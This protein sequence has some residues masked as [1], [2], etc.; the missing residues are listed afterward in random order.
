MFMK[1]FTHQTQFTL[2]HKWQGTKIFIIFLK[3]KERPPKRKIAQSGPCEPEQLTSQ[4][5]ER[6]EPNTEFMDPWIV[7]TKDGRVSSPLIAY[8]KWEVTFT[9]WKF[10]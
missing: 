4:P 7:N 8:L 3:S 6:D 9:F 5:N 1:K 10:C 2:K